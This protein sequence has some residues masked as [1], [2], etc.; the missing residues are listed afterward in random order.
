MMIQA[1][2]VF[3]FHFQILREKN[4]EDFGL[5]QFKVIHVKQ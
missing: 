2:Y 5:F 1:K 3:P 4:N